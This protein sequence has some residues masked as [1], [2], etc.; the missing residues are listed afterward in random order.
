MESIHFRCRLHFLRRRRILRRV[1]RTKK[2]E[3]LFKRDVKRIHEFG[4]VTFF[5]ATCT[6]RAVSEVQNR[7]PAT[8]RA[9]QILSVR[10]PFFLQSTFGAG[11]CSSARKYAKKSSKKRHLR[12]V[13]RRTGS[14]FCSEC[15]IGSSVTL[16]QN[17][18]KRNFA[19]CAILDRLQ[20]LAPSALPEAQ[21]APR[22]HSSN[23][24]EEQ[25]YPDVVCFCGARLQCC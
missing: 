24:T 6:C 7:G 16:L 9:G 2:P 13:S 22:V 10:P 1:Q 18:A 4:L 23:I 8:S 3:V 15:N 19:P 21:P 5:K 20:R 25:W 14:K 12:C 11:R 17:F